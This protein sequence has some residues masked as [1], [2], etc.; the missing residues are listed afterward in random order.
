MRNKIKKLSKENLQS[1]LL[2]MTELL[3][4]EQGKKLEMMIDACIAED[5][6]TEMPQIVQ[7]MSQQLVDDKMKQIESLMSQIDEGELYL[8]VD[9]YEDY[10]EGYWDR[11]WITDYYDNQGIGN[12]IESA[13]QFSKD[14]VDD[15]E[16]VDLELLSEKGILHTDMKQLALLTLYADYQV[17]ESDRRAA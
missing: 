4:Q 7:R 1:I 8:N 6:E 16:T 2:S 12:K 10:S 9:E 3:S 5:K 17:Q 14:C 11:E 13:I 15:S